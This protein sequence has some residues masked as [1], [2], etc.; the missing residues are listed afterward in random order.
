MRHEHQ[1]NGQKVTRF[2]LMPTTPE[3]AVFGKLTVAHLV[4]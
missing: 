1:D 4:K 2:V 3:A